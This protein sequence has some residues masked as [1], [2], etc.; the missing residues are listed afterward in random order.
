MTDGLTYR[1]IV[2]RQFLRHTI[3]STC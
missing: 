3:L 1:K 2:L